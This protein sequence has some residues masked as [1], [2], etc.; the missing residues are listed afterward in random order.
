MTP[1]LASA[2]D[3]E[4][5][6]QRFASSLNRGDV[7]LLFGPLG[8][9]KTTLVRGLARGMGFAGD[10]VSPTFTIMEVYPGHLPIYHFDFYRID[11]PEEL[12]A[13]DP[14]EYYDSGVTVMEWPERIRPWWPRDPI[15][16]HLAFS[17]GGRSLDMRDRRGG[18][19]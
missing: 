15:E 2:E 19:R 13:A 8:V 14:R 18:A 5:W 10:V 17:A 16:I 11:G 7:V 3:T 9:G 12:R 4:A 1:K 6:G